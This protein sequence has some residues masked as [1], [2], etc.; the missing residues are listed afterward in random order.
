[1]AEFKQGSVTVTYNDK[2]KI[3]AE[4]GSLS[5]KQVRDLP[6]ARRGVGLACSMTAEAMRK[7]PDKL[8]A[9]GVTPDALTTAGEMAES[10]DGVIAEL[11]SALTYFKQANN[12]LDA[13]AHTALRRVL[14]HVRAK[15]KFDA[16]LADLVPHLVAYFA[17]EASQP[18]PNP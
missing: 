3:P 6:K 14:A 1:M 4:A 9:D 10:V 7:H 15:E 12:I 17:N 13:E 18:T 16:R 8:A 11:E 5:P 2:L